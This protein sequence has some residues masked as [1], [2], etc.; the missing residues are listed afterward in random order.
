VDDSIVSLLHRATQRSADIFAAKFAEEWLTPRQYSV[1]VAVAKFKGS[2][3]TALVAATAIDRSTMADIVRRMV[4]KGLLQ[5]RRSKDDSRAY[6]IELTVAGTSA[7]AMA[8]PLM[9]EVE[10]DFVARLSKA[11]RQSLVTILKILGEAPIAT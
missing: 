4:K 5:R 11:Q 10:H 1:L 2:S 7:L 9:K 6:V 8:Q 3:Q